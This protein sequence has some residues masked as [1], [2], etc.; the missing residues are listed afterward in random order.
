VVVG[1]PGLYLAITLTGPGSAEHAKQ[2][3]CTP[4]GGVHL[5]QWNGTFGERFN[6]FVT[7]LRRTL[8][9]E[10]EYF[11][12]SE[13]QKR[14]ALHAHGIFRCAV[15]VTVP[16][17]LVVKLAMRHGFGH[18]VD[19]QVVKGTDVQRLARY[20]TKYVSKSADVR[21]EVPF[22]HR[23]TGEVGPG[24]WRLWT[25]SRSWGSSM[26]DVRQA[27]RVWMQERSSH[28]AASRTAGREGRRP[29]GPAAGAAGGGALDHNTERYAGWQAAAPLAVARPS[30][31]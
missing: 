27:Q 25:A 17:S 30:L 11:K 6:D 3:P 28:A 20:F 8:G 4:A 5:G 26:A 31:V 23:T 7:D 22:V 21:A 18:V 12:T 29:G 19:V 13:A 9:V 1:G 14:G 15:P 16:R 10:I 2:C 24:R